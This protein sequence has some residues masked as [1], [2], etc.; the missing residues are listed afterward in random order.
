M[1]SRSLLKLHQSSISGAS[2]NQRL[3]S[4]RFCSS[5]V[6]G[7]PISADSDPRTDDRNAVEGQPRERPRQPRGKAEN[8]EDIICRMMA[9]RDWT[10]RLQNSIRALV[11]Q[12]DHSLVYNVLHGARKPD[13][14][15]Q[16][17]RW[18]ERFGLFR[19][20]RETHLKIIE[21][22]GRASMLNHA[23]CIL[24][25][26]P[27]KGVQWDEDLFVVMIESYG[28]A[29]IVQEAVKIFLK[30]KELGVERTVTSYD[31]MF[32]VILR[33]GRYMMAKRYF[34]AMVS[35]GI[36]P[37]LHTY[38]IMIWGF[39]LS[40]RQ[41]T[42]IRFFEDMK[43]RGISPNVVTYNTMINGYI[44]FKNMDEAEKM[45]VEMK[46]KN[47]SP[48]VIS[49]TT[50][51]KGYVSVG[52][53]DDALKLLD[54][55]RG[56][57]I[58]S[59]D[60]TYTTLLPGLCEAEKMFEARKIL[61]EMAQRHIAPKDN[62]IFVNLLTSQCKSGNL[63]AATDVL[64]AMIRLSIPTEAGHYGILIENL[65]KNKV[66]DKAMSLLD[67]LVEKDIILRPQ[68]TLEMQPEAYNIMIEYLCNNG[69][70]AKAENFF[71]QLMKKGVQ[72]PIAF[73]NLLS[74]H[75][76]EGNPE[77]AFEILKIMDRIGVPRGSESYKLLIEGCL[78]KGEPADAKM[79]LDSMI[80]SGNLPE[81][82][83]FRTV[84]QSLFE[85]GRVQTA[86]RVMKTMVEKGVMENMDL[87]PKILEALLMRGHVEEALGRID[88]LMQN[89]ITPD[90]DTLLPILCDKGKTIAA[91]KLLD[92]GLERDC[93]ME[94]STYDKVLDAL[95]SAG[96]TLNAYS[97][98][99]KLME[100]E[101][102][103]S[104]KWSSRDDLI[105]SLNQEGYTKQ[106]DILSR[107][108]KGDKSHL[109]KKG[110]KQTA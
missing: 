57:G 72:D 77:S 70:T 31:A 45:F 60:V 88:L 40:L 47:L 28:K 18:V 46:G 29:G 101:G 95:L 87:V 80:E 1:A 10:T 67:K 86:S 37:T 106:A 74:G 26:M 97:I 55:M 12:F 96:K 50:M 9:N 48:T 62:S 100:K 90:F 27:K 71:R 84:M 21:I 58:K 13:H 39:F 104:T 92:F 76:K 11:P 53:I 43:N 110:K 66:F 102:G 6:E 105:K 108:V 94:F 64:K 36:E 85:D 98:L 30:M 49:Y 35:E 59:N 61:E 32:K 75:A 109:H 38:N 91:L 24:L 34:N 103:E 78:R 3:H 99:S 25:D 56:L 51:I 8:L 83:L 44:R 23:R 79:A 20:D 89:G 73:N 19:H 54:E 15:L 52:R 33:R 107:M 2:T 65:C 7:D 22:L 68:S 16:F 41:T 14:A 81:A 82:S 5:T 69:H 17:F 4:L 93:Q 63:D 42:A